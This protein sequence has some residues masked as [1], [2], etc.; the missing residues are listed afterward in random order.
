M[1]SIDRD[2][3]VCREAH[4]VGGNPPVS[5]RCLLIV[6]SDRF[7]PAQARCYAFFLSFFKVSAC[8]FCQWGSQ[9]PS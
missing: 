7:L 3:V 2:M 8:C 9:D 4:L 5:L 6:R 1:D